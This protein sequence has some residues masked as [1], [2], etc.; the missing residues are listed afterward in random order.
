VNTVRQS[1]IYY[2]PSGRL[3]L[4]TQGLGGYSLV[5]RKMILFR[6]YMNTAQTSG[7]TV[8]ATITYRIFGFTIRRSFM[9]P[10]GSLL[11]EQNG[12]LGSSVGVIFKGDAFPLSAPFTC[13]VEFAVQDNAGRTEH[14][15]IPQLEFSPPGRLRLLIHNLTGRAPWGTQIQ[16]DLSWLVEIFRGLERLGHMLPVRDGIAL[17]LTHAEAGINFLFGEN[18]D[19]WPEVCPLGGSPPCDPGE[20]RERNMRETNEIN[21]ANTAERVDAT[22]LWRPRDLLGLGGGE[23]VGGQAQYYDS[24]PGTGLVGMVGGDM[25]GR[26]FTGAILAQEIGHLFGCEPKDSPHFEDPLDGL[27]S[28]D[29]VLTDPFAFDFYR[30]K[31]YEPP[32][33]GFLGDVMN[34]F[35][36]GV[37]QGSDMVLFNAFDWEHLRKRFVKLPGI[38]GVARSAR[39]A[40]PRAADAEKMIAEALP[41]DTLVKVKRLAESLPVMRGATWQWTARGF[42]PVPA[43][44]G[45]RRRSPLGASAQSIAA[46]I[47]ACGVGEVH[48]PLANRPLPMVVNPNAH[49]TL[50]RDE[51]GGM[52]W[53]TEQRSPGR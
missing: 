38:G 21:A 44:A 52:Y 45:V 11:I 34:N 7:F 27:H 9:I 14:F 4:V 8:L 29:P 24:A 51:V 13:S 50:P 28:K 20:M 22:V 23:G 32:T 26:N 12:C 37:G 1:G 15:E 36:G 10:A 19:P 30:L 46:W 49:V 43:A 39:T 42:E 53:M 47:E 16:S 25:G 35:G 40:R 18:L 2:D 6:L 33:N 5:A 17:G 48:V 3:V 41:R 31:R